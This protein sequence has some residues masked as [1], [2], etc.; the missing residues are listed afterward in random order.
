MYAGYK[1]IGLYFF[2]IKEYLQI[3]NSNSTRHIKCIIKGVK[4]L[5]PLPIKDIPAVIFQYH[6]VSCLAFSMTVASSWLF[7]WN[8]SLSSVSRIFL[9]LSRIKRNASTFDTTAISMK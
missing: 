1:K 6:K 9:I 5:T 7:D 8:I 2:G 4:R 3:G